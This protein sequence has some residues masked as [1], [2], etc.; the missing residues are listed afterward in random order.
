MGLITGFVKKVYVCINIFIFSNNKSITGLISW[1]FK[2]TV[3]LE[4]GDFL[5]TIPQSF[6]MR[7]LTQIETIS[8]RPLTG[9]YTKMEARFTPKYTHKNIYLKPEWYILSIPR[10]YRSGETP[11]MK[12]ECLN[13]W[14]DFGRVWIPDLNLNIHIVPNLFHISYLFFPIFLSSHRLSWDHNSVDTYKFY[15]G[16]VRL[17]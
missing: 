11:L 4:S 5:C 10:T 7:K 15:V 17:R 2:K 3:L 14:N 16:I 12:I 9:C 8:R 6:Q 1:P 13:A